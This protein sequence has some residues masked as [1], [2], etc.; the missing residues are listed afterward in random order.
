M[1]G[2]GSVNLQLAARTFTLASRDR[3]IGQ[4][5]AAFD[6]PLRSDTSK[7]GIPDAAPIGSS[8]APSRTAT[9]CSGACAED[10]TL[11]SDLSVCNLP[12]IYS[13]MPTGRPTSAFEAEFPEF[14]T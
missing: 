13:S 5:A 14:F 1:L 6:R 11:T 2:P 12:G 4:L 9:R 7:V 10:G 8:R 3:R